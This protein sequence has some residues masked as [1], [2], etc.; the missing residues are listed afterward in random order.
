MN[1]K[2]TNPGQTPA[3]QSG[4]LRGAAADPPGTR[5]PKEERKLEI[6]DARPDRV[7]ISEAARDLQ[8]NL[9]IDRG[10][11]ASLGPER[12]RQV[13]ERLAE[14]YYDRPEVSG[15]ILRNLTGDLGRSSGI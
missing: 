1:I 2:P 13:L 7:E 4:P 5:A 8:Q 3:T 14:G 11:L 12:M 10:T 6:E 15:E 9:V